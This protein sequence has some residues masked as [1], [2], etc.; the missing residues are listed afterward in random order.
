MKAEMLKWSE[1]YFFLDI[2][3]HDPTLSHCTYWCEQTIG[4]SFPSEIL[5]AVIDRV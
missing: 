5:I 4:H 2:S 3:I 1:Q